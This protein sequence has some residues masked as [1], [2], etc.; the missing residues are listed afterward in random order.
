[1]LL[2]CH[3]PKTAGLTFLQILSAH[4]PEHSILDV[5]DKASLEAVKKID[6]N[7][8]NKYQVVSGHIPFSWIERC[9]ANPT[10]ITF[11]RDP[12]DRVLSHYN[13]VLKEPNDSFWNARVN[14]GLNLD[15]FLKLGGDPG[16]QQTRYI[17]GRD[18]S[19]SKE[20]IEE[21]I[22]KLEN[23]V[24]FTGLTEFFDES[25]LILAKQLNWHKIIYQRVNVG[26]YDKGNYKPSL[27]R[28][29]ED[30]NSRDRAIYTHMKQRLSEQIDKETHL[31]TKAVLEYKFLL[32][33]AST[34]KL[35]ENHI[36]K[37]SYDEKFYGFIED[38]LRF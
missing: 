1:M 32:H 35:T 36:N 20:D 6:D 37:Q 3:I 25:V 18:L 19:E 34:D 29:L 21:A 33:E 22:Y 8:F 30:Q 14:N 27:L 17:L 2:F 11:L 15:D 13:Y 31:F 10:V 23:I 24:N 7:T 5:R 9:R 28:R 38:Y 4:Y 16:D 12:V 26:R